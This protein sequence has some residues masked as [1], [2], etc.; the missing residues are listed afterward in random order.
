[1]P[2]YRFDSHI[3]VQQA[4]ERKGELDD[5]RGHSAVLA[6]CIHDTDCFG[7]KSRPMPVISTDDV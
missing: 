3:A 5:Y 2:C 4:T 7:Q 6:H 1:M